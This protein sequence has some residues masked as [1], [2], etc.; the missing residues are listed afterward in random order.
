MGRYI[1]QDKPDPPFVIADGPLDPVATLRAPCG[2]VAH[3]CSNGSHYLLAVGAEG[4]YGRPCAVT[5]N[6]FDDAVEALKSLPPPS[7]QLRLR[8]EAMD[9]QQLQQIYYA[10]PNHPTGLESSC[11][12]PPDA[13]T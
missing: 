3:I 2:G 9:P 4:Q 12:Q 10:S 5:Y 1:L 6:W 13:V 8:L 7:H 11:S